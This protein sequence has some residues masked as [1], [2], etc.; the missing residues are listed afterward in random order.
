MGA[1]GAVIVAML[2]LVGMTL[3]FGAFVLAPLG[4]LALGYVVFAT[5]RGGGDAG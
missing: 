1:V 5:S 3:F 4:A 2:L